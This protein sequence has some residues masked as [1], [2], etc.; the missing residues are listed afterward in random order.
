MQARYDGEMAQQN[1]EGGS[2]AI[3]P[4]RRSRIPVCSGEILGAVFAKMIAMSEL[5]MLLDNSDSAAR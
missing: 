5:S 3:A 2:T 1:P 4:R